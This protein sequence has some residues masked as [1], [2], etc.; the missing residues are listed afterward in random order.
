MGAFFTNLQVRKSSQQAVCEAFQKMNQG[1]AYVSPDA[2]NWVTVYSEVTED[3]NDETLR[4]IAG[5]LSRTLK[6]DVLAILVHDSDI[7]MYWLFRN[8]DLIDQFNSAPNYFEGAGDSD[9]AE[10]GDP[11]ALLPL[12]VPGTTR[13]QLEQ[14]LH[15][16]DGFPLMAEEIVDELAKLLGIDDARSNLGFNYFEGEGE[17]LLSDADEFLPVGKGAGRKQSR[18]ENANIAVGPFPDMYAMAVS[19]L[20]H[21]WKPEYEEQIKIFSKIAGKREDLLGR[22]R[23]GFDR[24]ARDVLKKSQLPNLPTLEELKAAR[25][26]GPE[27]L[28]VL[29]AQR[30]PAQITD[31]GMAVAQAGIEPFLAALF[32]QGLDPN[33]P[34]SRGLTIL[35]IAE[36]HELD[37]S[38]YR[39]TKAAAERKRP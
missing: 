24:G 9:E 5:A 36:R 27:A 8:G 37:S 15:P 23:D 19:M 6:T 39:L 34:D 28:A 18:P 35:Q 29:V 16:S 38:I 20:A 31:I 10:G 32:K 25:D 26:Q 14:I 21:I 7:A 3:Q 12:C 17:E 33:A 22:L 1:R 30:T 2:A 13:A 11:D 4:E